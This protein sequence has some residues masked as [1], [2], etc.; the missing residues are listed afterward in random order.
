MTK[1]IL[2]FWFRIPQATVDRTRV[3]S[4]KGGFNEPELTTNMVPL[5]TFGPTFKIPNLGWA[6]ITGYDCIGGDLVFVGV[7]PPGP[8]GPLVLS[9]P[10]SSFDS[11][12]GPS[13]LGVS[14]GG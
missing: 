12:Q 2:S 7:G 4:D 5:I 13:F 6:N 3:G 10:V 8:T 11:P 9:T 1:V 14:Y